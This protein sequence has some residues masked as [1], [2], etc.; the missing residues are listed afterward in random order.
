MITA[1]KSGTPDS[2]TV[3]ISGA[4][5]ER[6]VLEMPSARSRPERTCGSADAEA[7]NMT[8]T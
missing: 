8:C 3:G 7:E 4:A 5:A 1:S 2:A 6:L